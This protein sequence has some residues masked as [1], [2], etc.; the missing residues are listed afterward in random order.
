M[1]PLQPVEQAAQLTT[2]NRDSLAEITQLLQQKTPELKQTIES[3]GSLRRMYPSVKVAESIY[4]QE[5]RMSVYSAA[6]SMLASSD[7]DFDF[8]DIIVNSAAYRR[9]LAAA[10][11]QAPAPALPP[12]VIGEDLIDFSDTDTIQQDRARKVSIDAAALDEDL[13]GLRFSTIVSPLA[14]ALQKCQF[15]RLS[16]V[17]FCEAGGRDWPEV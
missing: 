16:R 6:D 1:P 3:T 11:H 9:A 8:D 14:F 13:L 2:L 12:V 15:L 7:L 10:R 5:D 17:S 4:S